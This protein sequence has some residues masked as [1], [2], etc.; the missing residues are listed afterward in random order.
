MI[1]YT[2]ITNGYDN[3]K[4]PLRVTPGWKYVCFSD[5]PIKSKVW[6]FQKIDNTPGIDRRIRIKAHEYFTSGITIYI[7][8]SYRISGDLNIFISQVSTTF[9]MERW[10]RRQCLYQEAQELLDRNM[11]D[12]VVWA[13]QKERY[14][15]EG[16]PEEWGM[17]RNGILVRDLSNR[18]VWDINARW[19]DE[20]ESGAKRDQLSL[21]YCFWKA[22]WRPELYPTPVFNK[23]FKLRN[24]LV[25]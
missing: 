3:L 13:T 2:V 18:K 20:W 1:V 5:Q 25:E 15:Q 16:Y 9:S 7:D 17:G 22:G 10:K 12:P 21:M 24:H 11:I 23:Y 6:E 14:Q 8:G 4:E 19:W